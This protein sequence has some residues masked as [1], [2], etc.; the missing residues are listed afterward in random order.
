M[1]SSDCGT[2]SVTRPM[3]VATRAKQAMTT[4]VVAIVSPQLACAGYQPCQI[5]PAQGPSQKPSIASR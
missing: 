1:R 4:A 2:G 5:A 3:K